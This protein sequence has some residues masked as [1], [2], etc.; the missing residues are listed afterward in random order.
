ERDPG[1]VVGLDHAAWVDP[2]EVLARAG[3]D[4]CAYE[5]IGAVGGEQGPANRAA[6]PLACDAPDPAA[7]VLT[8]ALLRGRRGCLIGDIL[9]VRVEE[10]L[11]PRTSWFFVFSPTAVV[12]VTEWSLHSHLAGRVKRRQGADF[13]ALANMA[14]ISTDRGYRVASRYA[15]T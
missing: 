5:Q 3:L 8:L 9:Q 10:M 13:A 15:R 12:G 6:D 11:H 4:A 1:A 2:A 7:D 14:A